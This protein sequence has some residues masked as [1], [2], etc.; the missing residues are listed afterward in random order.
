MRQNIYDDP[1]FFEYY[2]RLRSTGITYND[3]VEQ[4]AL[5]G[6]LPEL[7]GRQVL[8]MGCGSGQLAAYMIGQGAAH[9]T[10]ADISAR[11]L[12]L[13]AEH[14]KIRYIHGPMEELDFAA[15]SFDLI[16]SSLAFHYVE[17][18]EALMDRIARWLRPA[19]HLVFST[20]HPVTTAKHDMDG[21]IEDQQ[22]QRLHYAL[23]N[24]SEEG[25]RHTRW[26]VEDVVKYHRT[27]STLLNG[28]I[29]HGLQIE[30]VNEPEPI[31]G[32][33]EKMP[34]LVHEW[35]KPSFIIFRAVKTK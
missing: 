28:M 2:H 35:R 23:D 5:M 13:A 27:L 29:R 12:S 33:V 1:E 24:Y 25:I 18:Y 34:K 19:G 9:V 30:Q 22:G 15:D 21:W 16:V 11:M 7:Q 31:P 10:G 17:D 4:P 26:V 32:A 6:M 20:E 14:P 8:D 3:F